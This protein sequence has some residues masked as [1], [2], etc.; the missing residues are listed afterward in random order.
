MA[1]AS[2][3]ADPAA[4]DTTSPVATFTDEP[5]FPLSRLLD[6]AEAEAITGIPYPVLAGAL[7]SEDP[8]AQLTRSEVEAKAQAFLKR[9]VQQE[10]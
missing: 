8:G 3:S 10:G 1:A 4:T 6:Q 7:A 5:A 9:P 2:K